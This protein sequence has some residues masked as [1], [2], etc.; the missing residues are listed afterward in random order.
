MKQI[1]TINLSEIKCY[2]ILNCSKNLLP[3]LYLPILVKE[4]IVNK[5][6]EVDY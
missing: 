1:A 4:N 3:L 2:S 6:I 5:P